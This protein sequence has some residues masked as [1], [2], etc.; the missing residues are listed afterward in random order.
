M[1]A[2]IRLGKIFGIPLGINYSWLIVFVLVIFLMSSNFQDMYPRWS[3]ESRWAVAVLTTVLFFVSV[4][5]HELSH[6]LVALAWGIPVKGITLFI[7]GGVSQLAHDAQRPLTE[8]QV[9]VV[10]PATSL[11]LALLLW[12]A[13]ELVGGYNSH[14]N[15]V[16]FTLFAINL[17]LGIFNMLPGFPLDGGRVLRAGIWGATG[18]YWLATRLALHAGQGIGA[19]MVAGG[20]F[21]AVTGSF[22]AIWLA[23]VGGFLLYVATVNYRQESV[24]QSLRSYQ[25]Q[26]A[27]CGVWHPL[28]GHLPALSHEAPMALFVTGYTGLLVDGP[29][30]GI[31]TGRQLTHVN[32][33]SLQTATLAKIMT[34]LSAFPTIDAEA[35]VFDAMELMDETGDQVIALVKNGRPVGLLNRVE[36]LEL[37]RNSRR[38][39]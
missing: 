13:W 30:Y 7:F 32:Q 8:F 4:L 25:V 18:N 26:D 1:D 35:P 14:L 9:S 24:R 2:S 12:V 29:P 17:S 31:V 3:D 5:L 38:R 37:I 28:P 39:R 10:G 23:L 22:Q 6:S 36:L 16:L 21:W 11:A 27:L 19:I 34:P 20:I 33:R 15:A